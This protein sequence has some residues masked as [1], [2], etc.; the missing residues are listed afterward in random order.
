MYVALGSTSGARTERIGYFGAK[1]VWNAPDRGGKESNVVSGRSS[2][3]GE[4]SVGSMKGG[5]GRK[6]DSSERAK[7]RLDSYNNGRRGVY[8]E[9][10]YTLGSQ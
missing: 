5:R 8:V 9:M 2:V 4:G 10:G 7:R 1:E 6:R 3:H